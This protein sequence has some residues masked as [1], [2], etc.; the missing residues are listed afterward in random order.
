MLV[1]IS[2][3]RPDTRLPDLAGDSTTSDKEKVWF[4]GCDACSQRVPSPSL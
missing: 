1:S 4:A 3:I 2:F